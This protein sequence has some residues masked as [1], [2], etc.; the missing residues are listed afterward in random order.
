MRTT[1][2]LFLSAAATLAMTGGFLALDSKPA[3]ACGAEPTIG[4]I[5]YFPYNWCPNYYLPADGRSVA[6][7]NYQ[8]LYA[9]IGF[10]YGPGSGSSGTTFN[11]PD[12]RGRSA[13]GSGQGPDLTNVIVAQKRGKENVTLTTAQTPLVPHTHAATF[14]GTG[15][16]ASSPLTVTVPVATGNGNAST[17]T[18]NQTVG[19]AGLNIVDADGNV[20]YS[21]PYTATPPGS[22]TPQGKIVATAS[23]GG[24][25]TGGTVTV[26][27]AGQAAT[28]T[29]PTIP[30][31]LAVSA[32][33]AV[34]GYFPDRP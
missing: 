19:L 17:V 31:Q 6:V 28:A 29:T 24:G 22:G 30:P 26:A 15:G 33:I 12:L 20:T 16:G 9:L 32:C 13:I 18:A 10:L 11:L 34:N 1:K 14:T 8:A 5:C 2:S 4:E 3:Q 25:I 21:G 7:S 23:G 27:A